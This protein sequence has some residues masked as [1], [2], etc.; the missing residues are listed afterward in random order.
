MKFLNELVRVFW[1][2]A[3]ATLGVMSA[4]GCSIGL[5]WT[6]RYIADVIQRLAL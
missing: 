2:A 3:S 4:I 1:I 6:M 5:G